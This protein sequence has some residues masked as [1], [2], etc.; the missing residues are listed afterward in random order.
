MERITF[1]ARVRAVRNAAET[2]GYRGDVLA[3]PRDVPL[4]GTERQQFATIDVALA[5]WPHPANDEER[6]LVGRLVRAAVLAAR[7][8]AKR[9]RPP[10]R[11]RQPAQSTAPSAT[12]SPRGNAKGGGRDE[13][14]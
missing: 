6:E 11:T 12:P 4:V 5:A 1:L 13:K 9:R 2:L 10:R 14:R 7:R 8:P 3:D